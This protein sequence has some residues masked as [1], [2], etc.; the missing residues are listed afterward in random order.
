MYIGDSL[1][2]DNF[3]VEYELDGVRKIKKIKNK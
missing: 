2:P 3:I 1:R